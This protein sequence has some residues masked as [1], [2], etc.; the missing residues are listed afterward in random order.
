MKTCTRCGGNILQ[1][2]D[3]SIPEHYDYCLQCG[4]RPTYYRGREDGRDP[5]APAMCRNCGQHEVKRVWDRKAQAYIYLSRC[6]LCVVSQAVKLKAK[7]R[8]GAYTTRR[9]V[10]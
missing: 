6:A 5:N 7:Q 1:G 2:F 3:E 9:K 4:Y 10:A 8:R